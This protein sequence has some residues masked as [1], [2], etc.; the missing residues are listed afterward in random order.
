MSPLVLLDLFGIVVGIVSIWVIAGTKKT[1]GGKVGEALD[2]FMFGILAQILAFTWTLV[3]SR[4]K[5]IPAPSLDI[6]HL[7][8]AVGMILFVLSTK[9]FA[10]LTKV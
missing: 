3:F 7:L 4:L 6:H 9:K 10:S 1:V 2:L 8:M 5:L